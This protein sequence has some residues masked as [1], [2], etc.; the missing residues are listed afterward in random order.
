[1]AGK[2]VSTTGLQPNYWSSDKAPCKQPKL[3]FW[4]NAMAC[5]L[6]PSVGHPVRILGVTQIVQQR[7]R[8]KQHRSVT[9]STKINGIKTEGQILQASCYDPLP[10]T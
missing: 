1:M 6:G 8:G 7:Q 5:F 2:K 10:N 3:L 4:S 9:T